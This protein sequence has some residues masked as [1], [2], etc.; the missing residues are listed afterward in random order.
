MDIHKIDYTNEKAEIGYWI[1]EPYWGKGIMPKAVKK[2]LKIV[3]NK[4]KLK[5]IEGLAYLRNKP[6]QRV[7]EKSGFKLEGIKRKSI[8]RYGKL[9]DETIYAIVK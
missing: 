9:I 7:L 6:S 8:K 5:R 2:F 3:F 1:G 4:F